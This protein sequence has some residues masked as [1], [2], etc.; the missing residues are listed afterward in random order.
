LTR[1]ER[2]RGKADLTRLWIVGLDG[3]SPRRLH[4]WDASPRLH[5][6]TRD[7]RALLVTAD[8]DFAAP[9]FRIDASSGDVARIT[10]IAASGVHDH[11]RELPDGRVAGIRHTIVHPPEPFACDASAEPKLL[12]NL[13]GLTPEEGRAIATVERRDSPG[14]GG[15]PIGWLYVHPSAGS[16]PRAALLWIHGGPIS[17]HVDG[18]HWRWNALCAAAAGYAVALPNPR[19]STGRGQ[20]FMDGVQDNRWG[21]ACF[22]HLMSVADGLAREPAVDPARIVAMG[23]SFGGYMANW[24]GTQT[25]RFRAIVTH[26]S[27]FDLSMFHGTTDYPAWFALEMG[28]TPYADA[29]AF[30]RYSPRAHVA[31]WKTPTLI[32]HGERDYRVPISEGLV[33]FEALR[34]HGV[35]AELIV[36]PDE[37][38]WITKPRNIR[39]WYEAWLDF[40]ARHVR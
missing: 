33:L 28:L 8:D 4:D 14:D 21:E 31:Q 37:N 19:G 34:L 16:E 40:V 36:F 32:L 39:A 27:I 38:H 3:E 18:W 20:A 9:V 2:R 5:A 25:D 6:W 7:G 15:T 17:Q 29:A 26:A 12:A 10:S 1:P 35:D 22:H 11:I 30:A 24:I 23:G 13:S